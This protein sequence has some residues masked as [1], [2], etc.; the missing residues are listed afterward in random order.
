MISLAHRL[1]IRSIADGKNLLDRTLMKENKRCYLACDNFLSSC[2]RRFNWGPALALAI[3]LTGCQSAPPATPTP[4]S[5]EATIIEAS[6]TKASAAS[7]QES[8]KPTITFRESQPPKKETVNQNDLISR[9][10]MELSFPVENNP[11]IDAEINWFLNNPEYLKRVFSRSEPYLYHIVEALE[12]RKM[13]LDIALLPVVESAFDPFAY[14]HGRA[15]GLWQIIPGTGT[16]LGLKQNWW[17]DARRDVLESTRAAFDYLQYLHGLFEEDWLLALAGY[18][19]GEGNVAKAIRRAK[20]EGLPTDFWH[21]RRYLPAETQAYVP[22]LIALKQV[23]SESE[24]YDIQLPEI[25][26]TP[27]FEIV[28]TAGQM[29]MAIAAE[30]AN[31][32]T[33]EL[34][35]LN[36]G[37]NRWATDPEGPHRILVPVESATEFKAALSELSDQE[38]VSW[39][40]HEVSMGETLSQLSLTYQTT[41]RV[42]K[43]VNGLTNDMI[44]I[45]QNLMIPHATK[46]PEDYAQTLDARRNRALT[47]ERNGK[48][49]AYVVRKGDSLWTISRQHNATVR[50]LA[51]WNAMAPRDPLVV[52]RELTIWTESTELTQE[53][54]ARI[55]RLSYTV[56]KGDSLSRISMRFKVSISE[57][58]EWNDLSPQKHLQPGQQLVMFVDVTNQST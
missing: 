52:G 15:S 30:I 34:Y 4:A 53:D 25:A 8:L 21:I 1:V 57:L 47:Q 43:E 14:S 33:D 50:E 48:R 12:D 54:N 13:P 37:V 18:N 23:I 36:P 49:Q 6:S 39:S 29:D 44:R 24:H 5:Q 56:K 38:Q 17:F 40:R 19:S 22:R 16:Y 26:N 41:V 2:K 11:A 55:R 46:K 7:H 3:V 28:E 10:R 32:T 9:I 31:V 51:K 27:F 20:S 58:L 45:G 42:L 35:R